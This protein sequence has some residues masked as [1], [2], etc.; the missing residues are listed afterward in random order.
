MVIE[1]SRFM[2]FYSLKGGLSMFTNPLGIKGE[3][4][5]WYGLLLTR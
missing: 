3:I 2:P 4:S 5:D 1:L